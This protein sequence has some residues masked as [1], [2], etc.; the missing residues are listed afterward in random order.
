VDDGRIVEHW[1]IV[2]ALGLMTPLGAV[3]ARS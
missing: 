1:N 3:P 2:D